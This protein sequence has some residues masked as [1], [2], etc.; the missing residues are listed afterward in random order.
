MYEDRSHVLYHVMPKRETKQGLRKG[1]TDGA[2]KPELSAPKPAAAAAHAVRPKA[3]S[4]E[5]EKAS[6]A[7]AALA[8]AKDRAA[9]AAAVAASKPPDL[10]TRK[11]GRA[12][13]RMRESDGIA[14]T[15]SGESGSATSTSLRHS[16]GIGVTLCGKADKCVLDSQIRALNAK[17]DSLNQQ[18]EEQGKVL[19][20]VL[21]LAQQQQQMVAPLC[22]KFAMQ[23]NFFYAPEGEGSL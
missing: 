19:S 5:K 4:K 7:A 10:A 23:G 3:T 22:K 8:A 17:V 21:L 18:L 1:A 15:S 12:G 13:K 2:T 16:A 6:P 11:Q 20:S 9:L 14:G